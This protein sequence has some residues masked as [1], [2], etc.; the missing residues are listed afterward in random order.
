[1]SLLLLLPEF[2]LFLEEE[3]LPAEGHVGL[4]SS[5]QVVHFVGIFGSSKGKVGIVAAHLANAAQLLHLFA[6][7][8][9][10]SDGRESHLG[11]LR[12]KGGHD[13][14]LA[15]V[16]CR[17]TERDELKN[18]YKLGGGR[19]GGIET[20]LDILTS[21]KNWPSSIP[22]TSKSFHSSPS[23][24]RFLQ[25]TAFFMILIENSELEI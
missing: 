24:D 22:I 11:V 9:Q 2:L 25:A 15:A 8:N 21:S 19:N 17:L 14:D 12:V 13:Y 23:S 1:M 10:L 6:Q 18:K 7:G 3:A 16:R 4:S 5:N 20:G